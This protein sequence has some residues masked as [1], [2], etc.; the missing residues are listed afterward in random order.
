VVATWGHQRM[1]SKT[2]KKK[3]SL[4]QKKMLVIFH[5]AK[6]YHSDY[7]V[8]ILSRLGPSWITETFTS[9]TVSYPISIL[10]FP[11]ESPMF[12]PIQ[13]P[14]TMVFTHG[15]DQF[16]PTTRG[17]Q[18]VKTPDQPWRINGIGSI[19]CGSRQIGAF[20][21]LFGTVRCYKAVFSQ[22]YCWVYI[23]LIYC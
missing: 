7:C 1:T 11:H 5:S 3:T 14:L 19:R 18:P 17:D 13:W 16:L 8:A 12:Y 23:W 22:L 2:R 15:H 6:I 20:G 9:V 21:G 4:I 10:D